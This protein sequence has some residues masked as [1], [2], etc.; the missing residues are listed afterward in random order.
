M[1]VWQT[2]DE[3]YYIGD[4]HQRLGLAN[5]LGFDINGNP[6]KLNAFVLKETDGWTVEHA[7]I[8]CAIRNIAE[9]GESSP[10]QKE[11]LSALVEEL[12]KMLFVQKK[13]SRVARDLSETLNNIARK[14]A[15]DMIENP[16]HALQ[17][18][19]D[20]FIVALQGTAHQIFPNRSSVKSY[21]EPA[22]RTRPF[23]RGG[24][25]FW[26]ISSLVCIEIVYVNKK[27]FAPR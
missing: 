13:F 26:I 20:R 27:A 25:S 11:D 17:S 18:A 21:A 2:K 1:I 10:L 3:T 5:R 9:G 7:R 8:F 24:N 12:E 4:G 6:I 19:V 16:K 15:K 22:P 14:Y 23:Y